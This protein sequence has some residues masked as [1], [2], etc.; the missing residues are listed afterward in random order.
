MTLGNRNDTFKVEFPKVFIPEEVKAKYKD[1][2]FR[3][4]LNIKDISEL[5][6][7]SIQSIT[8]PNFKYEPV[9]QQQSGYTTPNRGTIRTYRPAISKE[10]L[11]DRK[12]TITLSLLD[13]NINYWILLDTFFSYYSFENT[14]KNIPDISVRIYNAEGLHMYTVLFKDCLFTSMGEFTLSYSELTPEFKTF[15]LEFTFNEMDIN[16]ALQ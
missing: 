14:K 12:F 9:E 15:E 7:Y 8:V 6:N 10:L 3:L 11:I 4:P 5:V 2:V 1:Y 16:F 13:G